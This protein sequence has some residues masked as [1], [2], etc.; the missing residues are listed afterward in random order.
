MQGA[1]LVSCLIS[2]SGFARK[3]SL[4][5][6]LDIYSSQGFGSVKFEKHVCR[7]TDSG[8][9]AETYYT[10]S[11]HMGAVNTSA[12]LFLQKPVRSKFYLKVFDLDWGVTLP[13]DFQTL[14][15]DLSRNTNSAY[16]VDADGNIIMREAPVAIDLSILGIQPSLYAQAGLTIPYLPWIILRVGGGPKLTYGKM[17]VDKRWAGAS[18]RS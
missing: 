6:G 18:K 5:P 10:T 9:T 8:Q 13:L 3:A 16:S 14:S 17:R 12:G 7:E 2:S 11:E 15:T 1:F 4:R